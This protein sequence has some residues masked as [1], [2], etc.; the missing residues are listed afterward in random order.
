M[1]PT[2]LLVLFAL[3]LT[4]PAFAKLEVHE[5]GTFTS[6]V[7]SNGITQNGMYHEDEPLPDFVHG[8]GE[9]AQIAPPPSH[10]PPIGGCRFKGCFG[11]DFLSRKIITQK[12]ETP[13][14]YF[15]SDKTQDVSVNVKFPKGVIT[16]TYPAPI[17]T[18]PTLATVTDLKNGNTTFNVKIIVPGT[19]GT[20]GGPFDH[21]TL[22][23]VDLSNIYG[24]ARNV[25]SNVVESNGE[26]EKYIFYRGI[27]QYQ[28]LFS[29]TSERGGVTLTANSQT[30]PQVAFLIDVDQNGR[31]R[32]MKLSKFE[33]LAYRGMMANERMMPTEIAR[34]RDHSQPDSEDMISGDKASA[35]VVSGLVGAGLK[36]DEAQAMVATWEHGYLKVPGLR[37]LSILQRSEVDAVLPLTIS[38]A[39]EKVERVFVSRMEIL[40]DTDEQKILRDIQDQ[41]LAFDVTSLGRFAEPKLRRVFDV[42]KTSICSLCGSREMDSIFTTLIDRALVGAEKSG[43]GSVQ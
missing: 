25:E 10:R 15:Y 14:L 27:G 37:L 4:Q 6:L 38:P 20:P 32:L 8:F 17:A 5:W 12:M 41:G 31:A 18:S 19:P 11:Q 24:H 40:L 35:E 26:R 22:P 28:P 39:P 43:S 9:I 29:V 30:V 42:C 2:P 36:L 16:E 7:G 33:M 23:F 34:L 1:R 3:V 21:L 13:V